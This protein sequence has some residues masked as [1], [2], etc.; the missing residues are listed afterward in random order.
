M[1]NVINIAFLGAPGSGKG[2]QAKLLAERFG[3]VHINTGELLRSEQRTG[4]QLG[5]LIASYIDNGNLVP[6]SVS[7]DVI[8]KRISELL[9]SGEIG[10]GLVF[11]GYPRSEVQAKNLT[12][13]L[14]EQRLKLDMS[15]HFDIS[16][17][18]IFDRIKERAIVENRI[19]D[20]DDE[21]IRKRIGHYNHNRSE[22]ENYYKESG[23]FYNID[24]E[25]SI[26]S[27][28]SILSNIIIDMRT[29]NVY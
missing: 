23:T 10:N 14:E 19:D 2:T 18:V 9:E 4:S 1:E 28:F 6:D 16:D 12:S 21:S 24:G 17:S 11:D 22:I 20:Q 29:E 25:R 3:M 26:T 15:I 5:Q 27:I 7:T 13:I 8:R